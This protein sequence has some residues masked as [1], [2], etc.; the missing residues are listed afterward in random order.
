MPLCPTDK[1]PL[2]GWRLQ[3]LLSLERLYAFFPQLSKKGITLS[4]CAC[5]LMN[6]PRT[7]S[8]PSQALQQGSRPQSRESPQPW[9][10]L[11]IGSFS[12][13][14][15]PFPSLWFSLVQIQSYTSTA[16][17]SL[18]FCLSTEGDPTPPFLR[19]QFAIMYLWPA[20]LS[21][22]SPGD[23]SVTR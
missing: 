3:G 7:G 23:F 21:P 14:F 8:P 13:F 22:W 17:L 5:E 1:G 2:A 19:H 12:V 10:M 11:E 9:I 18:P 20:N 4:Y 16:S 15:F 6:E